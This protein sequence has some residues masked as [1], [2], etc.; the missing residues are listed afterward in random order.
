M[1]GTK[2]DLEILR[3]DYE[4]QVI[5]LRQVAKYFFRGNLSN[6]AFRIKQLVLAGLLKPAVLSSRL[7]IKLFQLTPSGVRMARTVTHLQVPQRKIL[8]LATLEHDLLVTDVRLRLKQLWDFAWLP[9]KVLKAAEY[10]QIPDGICLFRSGKKIAIELEN[11]AKGSRRYLSIWKRWVGTETF[12]VLY[13]ATNPRL[14]KFL[15][16]LIL[17][18]PAGVRLGVVEWS[19]LDDYTPTV[20]TPG[21]ELELFGR[22][23]F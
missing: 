16:Q 4:Q 20:W 22:L 6:A 12:L 2:R 14:A 23:E 5:A 10:R 21:G 15:R 1:I 19:Q 8:S 11:S 13:V 3:V 17:Q 9:E 18:A 7:P